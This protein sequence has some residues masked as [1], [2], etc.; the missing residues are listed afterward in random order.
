MS[1]FKRLLWHQLEIVLAVERTPNA[2]AAAIKDMC[3]DNCC[4][5]VLM[6]EQ[7][8]NS[9]NVVTVLEQMGGKAMTEGVATATFLEMF[10]SLIAC[11]TP[12]C[13]TS[14]DTWCRRF[15]P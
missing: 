15:T 6:T 1:Q 9:S 5:H 14:G 10:A 3:I 4:P 8:L 7:F 2:S 12:R 13:R 11:L